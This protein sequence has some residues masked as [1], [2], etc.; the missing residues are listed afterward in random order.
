MMQQAFN[1]GLLKIALIEIFA[2]KTPN[3]MKCH[4]NKILGWCVY[5]LTMLAIVE[6]CGY[7]FSGRIFLDEWQIRSVYIAIPENQTHETDFAI[8]LTHTII[9]Q[10]IQRTP[11]NI[12]SHSEADAVLHGHILS[13]REN[14][15]SRSSNGLSN[16]RRIQIDFTYVF[17]N[18]KDTSQKISEKITISDNYTSGWDKSIEYTHRKQV[19]K[20]IA[21]RLAE[22]MIH[23]IMNHQF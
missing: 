23:Q 13:I 16:E 4:V 12:V 7:H 17:Q 18:I 19:L 3:N 21:N 10:F 9:D 11:L 8:E 14:N 2:M 22:K 15:L 20:K 6:G 1:Q 5:I